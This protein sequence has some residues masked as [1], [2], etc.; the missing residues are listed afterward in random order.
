[1]HRLEVF[2]GAGHRRRWTAAE[3]ARIVEETCVEGATVSAVARRYGLRPQQLFAWRRLALRGNAPHGA[4]I[5]RAGGVAFAPV[6]VT[7]SPRRDA[8]SASTIEVVVGTMTV[9]VRAGADVET[10][11]VVLRAAQ[12]VS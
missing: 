10:L 12:A 4:R 6:V 2:T 7:T 11:Q 9:R 1:V 3:K 8:G 5:A